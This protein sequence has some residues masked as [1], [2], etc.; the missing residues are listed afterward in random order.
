VTPIPTDVTVENGG[1]LLLR[2]DPRLLFNNVDFGQ[3]GQF[4]DTYGFSDDPS[5]GNPESPTFY[6]QPSANLFDNLLSAGTVH[7]PNVYS[8]EWDSRL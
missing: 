7:G 5:D 2:I 3:L 8:F 1:G 6:S 4:S